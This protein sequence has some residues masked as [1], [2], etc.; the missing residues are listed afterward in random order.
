MSEEHDCH[1]RRQLFPERRAGEAKRHGR[2]EPERH[3]DGERDQRHH[4]WQPRLELPPRTLQEWPAADKEDHGAEDGRNQVAA[5]HMGWRISQ[6]RREHVPPHE[7][8]NREQ[9]RQPEFAPEQIN[10]VP[11]VLAVPVMLGARD[12]SS[13]L[14]VYRTSL[15]LPM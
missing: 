1:Q 7:R 3:A 15:M 5:G 10:T 9:E 6:E 14:V 13:R 2:A 4:A 12:S 8:W 11:H